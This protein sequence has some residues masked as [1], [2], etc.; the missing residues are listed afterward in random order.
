MG[1]ALCR[2]RG[3]TILNKGKQMKGDLYN[4]NQRK[5]EGNYGL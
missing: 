2:H 5:G 1:S 3:C 4:A